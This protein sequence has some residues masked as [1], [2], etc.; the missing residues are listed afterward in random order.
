[1]SA[2]RK[3]DEKV[4]SN[5]QGNQMKAKGRTNLLVENSRFEIISMR[6]F[7]SEGMT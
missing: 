3:E 1:L 5:S 6:T 7:L 4:S 2:G